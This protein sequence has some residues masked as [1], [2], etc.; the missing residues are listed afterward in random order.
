[1]SCWIVVVDDEAL[2]LTNAKNI[3]SDQDMRVSCLRSGRDL[4]KFMTKNDPD[5]ILLDVLM[6]EMDG[7]ETFKRLRRYEEENGK[8]RTPVIFLTGSDDAET[9]RRGLS[10][11]ASDFIRKPFHKDILIRRI[12]NTI[13]NTRKIENLTTEA[14][15]DKLTGFL[16][17]AAGT[18]QVAKLCGTRVGMLLVLDLDNFKLINDL[19]GHTM[20]DKVLQT[21]AAVV[22]NNVRGKDLTVR[23]GGDE[24]MAFCP[25]LNDSEGLEHLTRRLNEQFLG[26]VRNMIGE[27]FEVPLGVSVGAVKVPEHGRSY[28][29]IFPLADGALYRAKQNGKHDCVLYRP[30]QDDEFSADDD[31]R[32]SLI[33][34]T[35]I[36][37]ERNDQNGALL[38]GMEQFSFIYRFI[39]R[40]CMRYGG[41]AVK[42]MFVLSENQ[43]EG[44]PGQSLKDAEA[45]FGF[46][47]KETLRRSDILTQNRANEFFL[48]LPQV[49]EE[50]AVI[51][52]RRIMDQWEK[53]GPHGGITVEYVSEPLTF[54]K[55]E[56]G[57]DDEI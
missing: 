24:F 57:L 40:F 39:K 52:V 31:I 4:L 41:S 5:L 29:E 55:S 21:F 11:G 20:G 23:I 42:M 49:S 38:M 14:E 12:E 17:K 19:Y 15:V 1:M 34:L 56:D 53:L 3:L 6:P 7:F 32:K 8:K 50:D 18:K 30:P 46:C 2:S 45:Q 36:V 54:D 27:G 44:G 10:A 47:L 33:R 13:F 28:A 51:V 26:E 22:R 43:G 48:L 37:E 35:Q 25:D 16:N 9:E